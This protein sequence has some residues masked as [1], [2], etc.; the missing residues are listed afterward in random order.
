MFDQCIYFNTSALARALERKWAAAFKPLGLAPPQAFMLRAVLRS[1]GLL[2]SELASAMAISRPTATRA[3]DG[4]AT[5][6]FVDRRPTGN[7]GRQI[8]I[9]PTRQALAIA[10]RLDAA[11]AK[12]TAQLKKQL[13]DP[14]FQAMVSAIRGVRSMLE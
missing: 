2:Q 1:P 14:E 3:L 5:K 13:G 11:S 7:D 4:L 8:A 9:F 12:V 10:S 6:G